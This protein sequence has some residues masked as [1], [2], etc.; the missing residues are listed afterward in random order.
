LRRGDC[1]ARSWT[2]RRPITSEHV[3][4]SF[5]QPD[6]EETNEETF[7]FTCPGSHDGTGRGVRSV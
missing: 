2:R 6:F 3:R 4:C 5:S 1:D 7:C